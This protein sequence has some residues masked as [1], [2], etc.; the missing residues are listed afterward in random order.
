MMG[1]PICRDTQISA[2]GKTPHLTWSRGITEHE[3]A[4]SGFLPVGSYNREAHLY[5]PPSPVVYVANQVPAAA[6]RMPEFDARSRY[7]TQRPIE[8]TGR[9]TTAHPSVAPSSPESRVGSQSSAAARSI[10]NAHPHEGVLRKPG[11]DH[12]LPAGSADAS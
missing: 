1:Y 4:T 11:C 5:K 6:D 2:T 3:I 10:G 8:P 12:R 7:Q 9:S